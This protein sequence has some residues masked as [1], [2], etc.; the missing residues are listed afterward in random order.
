MPAFVP[1][2]SV[3]REPKRRTDREAPWSG[4]VLPSW[5]RVSKAAEGRPDA[6]TGVRASPKSGMTSG[7]RRGVAVRYPPDRASSP[8]PLRWGTARTV[9]A[10]LLVAAVAIAVLVRS[11][12]GKI[13]DRHRRAT[14]CRFGRW[15][16]RCIS[17]RI[18]VWKFHIGEKGR[19]VA[20]R[21]GEAL[22]EV[23]GIPHGHSRRH[24][25]RPRCHTRLPRNLP[26][27]VRYRSLPDAN[28][29]FLKKKK[30]K[31]KKK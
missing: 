29:F 18:R 7:P 10:T 28:G 19:H 20:L 16:A 8:P 12:T 30:K 26:F 21:R 24:C 5:K 4:F 13:L 15:L 22:F 11:D 3:R 17:T 2:R 6:A 23:A 14:D 31:K 1:T 27:L 25:R 9:V